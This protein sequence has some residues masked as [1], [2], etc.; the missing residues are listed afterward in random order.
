MAPEAL[1]YSKTTPRSDIFRYMY[2]CWQCHDH[3]FTLAYLAS[4][5]VLL[6]ELASQGQ[7]PYEHLN[8]LHEVMSFL[9]SEQRLVFPELHQTLFR[10][11]VARADKRT[12]K[13]DHIV[14]AML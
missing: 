10:P 5:G 1:L 4:F 2:C 12:D 14:A 11:Y 9:K 7:R 8:T 13:F 6:W 3:D